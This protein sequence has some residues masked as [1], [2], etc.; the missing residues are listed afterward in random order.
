[1]SKALSLICLTVL[2]PASGRKKPKWSGKVL[3]GAGDGFAAGQVFGLEVRAVGGED[4]RAL[5]LA[6]GGAALSAA[7]VCVTS[8]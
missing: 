3:V 6:G 2:M 5:A 1:M 8:P 7:S 4:E